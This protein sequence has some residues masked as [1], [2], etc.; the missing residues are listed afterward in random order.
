MDKCDKCYI[1]VDVYNELTKVNLTA[2]WAKQQLGIL[3]GMVKDHLTHGEPVS[4]S[5]PSFIVS[6]LQRINNGI[7]L[8][9]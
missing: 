1:D 3:T 5:F 7:E 8:V 6:E 2:G 9:F 4:P